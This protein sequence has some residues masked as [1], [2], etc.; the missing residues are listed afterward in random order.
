MHNFHYDDSGD[1]GYNAL[2]LMRYKRTY[3]QGANQKGQL[4]RPMDETRK[5]LIQKVL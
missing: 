2:E 4:E 1:G 3:T 5:W